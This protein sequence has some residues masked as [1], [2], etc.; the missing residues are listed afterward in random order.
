MTL[1][2][3]LC[4]RLLDILKAKEQKLENKVVLFVCLRYLYI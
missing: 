2:E 1:F 3:I 4:F